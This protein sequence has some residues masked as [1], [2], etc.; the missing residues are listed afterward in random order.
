[1]IDFA[2]LQKP[3]I[4]TKWHTYTYAEIQKLIQQY[5]AMSRNIESDKVAIVSENRSEWIFAFYAGWLNGKIVV[6]IDHT[7]SVDDVAY[8]LNDSRPGVVYY[9]NGKKETIIEAS[10]QLQYKPEFVC[11]DEIELSQV[12]ESEYVTRDYPDNKTA[13]IVYTSGT[14]GNAV[15]P[16]PA[17]QRH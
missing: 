6:P 7:A 14:T 2:N 13:I 11:L 9:S 1:M 15:V 4:V 17:R 10:R 16:E 3:A 12:A 5:A 8:M